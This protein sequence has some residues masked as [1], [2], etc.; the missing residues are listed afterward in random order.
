MKLCPDCKINPKVP[1]RTYCRPCYNKRN[2]EK[3]GPRWYNKQ[4][5][6]RKRYLHRWG[7][8]PSGRFSQYK[9]N[10][11]AEKKEFL[12]TKEFFTAVTSLPCIYC[13]GWVNKELKYTG[14]DRVDSDKGYIQGNVVPCCSICN[15]MKNTLTVD[16]FRLHLEK[17]NK[18]FQNN[19]IRIDTFCTESIG[20]NS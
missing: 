10:A 20:G 6:E 17:V 13:E 5:P 11:K 1:N 15:W 8:S 16:Q 19:E 2:R 12:L 14:L 7:K 4:S 18:R 9:K 3:Y